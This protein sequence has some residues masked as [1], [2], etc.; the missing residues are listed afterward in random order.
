MNSRRARTV[1]MTQRGDEGRPA[2]SH[3]S[4]VAS[5]SVQTNPMRRP[6]VGASRRNSREPQ[7]SP[8]KV[9]PNSGYTASQGTM[10]ATTMSRAYVGLLL[11]SALW[12][13]NPGDLLDKAPPDVEDALRD[14]I[15]AFYQA[16]VDRKFRQAD[17]YVAQ[18]T[19][20][21]YYEANKPGYLAFEIRKLT[22]ADNFTSATPISTSQTS[23]PL[24]D[25]EL[26]P[27]LP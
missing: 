8:S 15:T 9:Q 2:A 23:S 14:R 26:A 27:H 6:S 1:S 5:D 12:A 16:H 22:Y 7:N 4:S 24:P 10:K 11:V 19:K 18:D 17:D 13:Q 25:F 3:R 21:F 20:D